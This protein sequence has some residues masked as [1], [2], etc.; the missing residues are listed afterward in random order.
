MSEHPAS[1]AR[2]PFGV[3]PCAPARDRVDQVLL[4]WARERPDLDFTPV[5]VITRLSRART[6]LDAELSAVFARFGLTS[7][8]FTVII[9]LRRAGAPYTL[10]QARLMDALGLTSGTVSVRLDRLERNG[11]VSREPDPANARSSIVRLTGKGLRLFDE[12]APVHLANEDRLLSALSAEDRQ[13]LADLLRRLLAGFEAATT[14]VAAGLGLTLEP[15]HL[16][17]ARRQAVGLSD[18]AGLLVSHVASDSAAAAAGIERGDLIT[19]ID[20]IATTSSVGL[21]IL[22]EDLAGRPAV[23]VTLLRGNEPVTA[24]L[25]LSPDR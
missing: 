5:G 20:G 25:R 18:T 21:A 17:R 2:L 19:A 8:D 22:L 11:I 9:T 6:Y 12:I 14:D 7:A 15:A 23:A 13:S 24:T 1:G 4:D 16:A 3:P 10:P